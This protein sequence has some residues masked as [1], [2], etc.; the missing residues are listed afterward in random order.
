MAKYDVI[1]VG[2]GNGGLAAA[3]VLSANGL[4]V[5][6]LEKHNVPGGC[7]TSF[8]RGRYEFEVALH[9]LSG[10]GSAE[11]PGRLR[12]F[13]NK[14]DVVDKLQWIEM[15]N[16]YRVISADSEMDILLS[17]DRDELISTLQE[18]FPDQK[19]A[20]SDFFDLIYTW[21]EQMTKVLSS[22]EE[23]TKEQFPVYFKYALKSAGEVLDSFFTDEN[24]KMI[25]GVYWTYAG[26]SLK[27][28]GFTNYAAQIYQYLHDK[29]LSHC[30]RLA[31]SFQHACGLHPREWRRDP[32]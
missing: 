4:K 11:S 9:Q 2:A 31:G 3:A 7:A 15:E 12:N 1:V 19:Q 25:L 10:F 6:V 20:I 16:L 24:L 27:N 32:I 17:S 21:F 26:V 13:L 18:K 5:L 23:V 30:R 29:P 14:L 28:W 8:C 22:K